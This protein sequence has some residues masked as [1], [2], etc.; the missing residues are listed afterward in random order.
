MIL[1]MKRVMYTEAFEKGFRKTADRTLF[2]ARIVNSGLLK[3]YN[4]LTLHKREGYVKYNSRI[5]VQRNLSRDKKF[6][7]VIRKSG[8]GLD[9]TLQNY[10][11]HR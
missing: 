1:E 7:S 4:S 5:L 8:C 2:T 3:N 11:S 9:T 6:G 10:N